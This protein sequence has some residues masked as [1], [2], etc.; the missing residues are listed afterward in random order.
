MEHQLLEDLCK[1][2]DLISYE[3]V[4]P[5]R[6]VPPDKYLVH[7]DVK[8]IIG[9]EEEGTPIYGQR[10]TAKITLPLGYPMTSS[11]ICYM[12]TDTW[13]PNIRSA[14]EYKGHICINAQVLGYWHTLDMLVQQIGEMLQYKNYHALQI[15]PYPEDA[16]V[17]KW[18]REYAEPESIVDKEKGI[19]VDNRSLLNPTHKWLSS[20]S[21]KS[22]IIV[23]GIRPKE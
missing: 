3:V 2:S 22:K 14:G 18:V 6:G 10:H 4:K 20:R 19:V 23:R 9:I 5:R 13:H 16:I 11:P 15:Q 8:S 1:H 7:F 17:A 12:E 21:K